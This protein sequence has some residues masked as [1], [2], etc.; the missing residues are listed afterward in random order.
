[1]FKMFRTIIAILR[2]VSQYFQLLTWSTRVSN[3]VKWTR[4]MSAEQVSP[5][6]S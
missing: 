4:A 3:F 1:M 2:A 5:E 6:V